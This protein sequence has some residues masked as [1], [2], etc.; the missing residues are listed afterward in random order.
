MRADTK[1]NSFFNL[2]YKMINND[3]S[4]LEQI[5]YWNYYPFGKTNDRG[6]PSA[7]SSSLLFKECNWKN[8]FWEVIKI[9]KPEI[10]IMTGNYVRNWALHENLCDR[11]IKKVGQECIINGIKVINIDHP[12]WLNKNKEVEA[13]VVKKVND[14]IL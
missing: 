13:E 3:N 2:F 14:I 1:P 7:K 4:L 10:V 8:V 6:Y 5:G 12:S 9:T 11:E